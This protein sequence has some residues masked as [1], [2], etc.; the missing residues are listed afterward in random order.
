MTAHKPTPEGK[1]VHRPAV[2]RM[3]IEH[4]GYSDRH[5][6]IYGYIERCSCGARRLVQ[7]LSAAE[8]EDAHRDAKEGTP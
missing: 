8:A 2:Y 5:G 1:H 4:S 6:Y 7:Y 3:S